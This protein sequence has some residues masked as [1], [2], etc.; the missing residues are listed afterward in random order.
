MKLA[1]AQA[2]FAA[3][4]RAQTTGDSVEWARQIE[5]AEDLV[6]DAFDLAEERPRPPAG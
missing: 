6:Q 3:A 2:A 1:Q 5:R 4:E